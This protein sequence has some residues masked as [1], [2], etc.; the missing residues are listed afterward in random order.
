MGR[1]LARARVLLHSIVEGRKVSTL[2]RIE[3]N[4]KSTLEI[5]TLIAL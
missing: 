2:S 3:Q 1:Y 5:A 4:S